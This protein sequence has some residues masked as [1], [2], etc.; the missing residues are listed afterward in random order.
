MAPGLYPPYVRSLML[1]GAAF[2]LLVHCFAVALIYLR[3]P[4]DFSARQALAASPVIP[5]IA[6]LLV[7]VDARSHREHVFH[8]N[9]GVAPARIAL[10]AFATATLL[11][12]GLL[13]A[14]LVAGAS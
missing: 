13:A 3:D 14:W 8:A 11:E 7:L 12:I 5:L 4:A 1:R 10:P 2:W 6:A 9:L